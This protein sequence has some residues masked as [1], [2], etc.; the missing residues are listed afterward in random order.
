LAGLAVEPG[1]ARAG[2]VHVILSGRPAALP[3]AALRYAEGRLLASRVVDP[4][5]VPGLRPAPAGRPADAP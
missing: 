5:P 1:T 3:P 4:S 2:T